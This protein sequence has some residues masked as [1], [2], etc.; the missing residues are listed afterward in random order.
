[1]KLPRRGLWQRLMHRLGLSSPILLGSL[2]IRLYTRSGCH[3]C[4]DALKTLQRAREKYRFSL[5]VLDVDARP[6]WVTQW[7]TCVPVVTV[8]DKAR[9]RGRVNPVL[10]ERLLVAESRRARHP[11]SDH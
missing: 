6:E 3:L 4:E 8:N 10:L 7:G 11:V 5:E 2:K 9:F 1:M